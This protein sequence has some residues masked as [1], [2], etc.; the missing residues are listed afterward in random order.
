MLIPTLARFVSLLL[1][2]CIKQLRASSPPPPSPPPPPATVA[3]WEQG[4]KSGN[5]RADF[6]WQSKS[7]EVDD[8]NCGAKAR[9]QHFCFEVPPYVS[10]LNSGLGCFCEV[11]GRSKG[12]GSWL[13]VGSGRG[14]WDFSLFPDVIG[15]F[16]SKWILVLSLSGTWVANSFT[17]MRG[18]VFVF[19]R[20][21]TWDACTVCEESNLCVV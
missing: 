13:G 12:G 17:V 7:G 14:D 10:A 1:L 20:W 19:F 8:Q 4:L 16:S 6:D 3:S 9:S 18:S 15:G 21:G 5:K 2:R 11:L